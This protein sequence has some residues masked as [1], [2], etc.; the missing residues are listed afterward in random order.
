MHSGDNLSV[1]TKRERDVLTL[2]GYGLSSKEIA[3][4]LHRSI[5]TVNTHRS[6]L[7]RKLGASNRVELVHRQ[8]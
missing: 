2:I 7:G 1:L 5:K 6:A 3:E 4:R 8:G